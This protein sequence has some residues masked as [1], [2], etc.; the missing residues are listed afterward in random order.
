MLFS[1]SLQT[2]KIQ[3]AKFIIIPKPE[4]AEKMVSE[5]YYQYSYQYFLEN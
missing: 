5:W 3:D 4:F 1:W 2:N